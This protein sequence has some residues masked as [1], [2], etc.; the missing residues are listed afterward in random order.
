MYII[1]KYVFLV[2]SSKIGWHSPAKNDGTHA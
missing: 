1:R 2:Y